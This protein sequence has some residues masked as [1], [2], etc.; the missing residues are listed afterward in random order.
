MPLHILLPSFNGTMKPR[1][2]RSS[3]STSNRAQTIPMVG[4]PA[5]SVGGIN[6]RVQKSGLVHEGE[7]SAHFAAD[8][9]GVLMRK[10]PDGIWVAVV[11]RLDMSRPCPTS[12]NRN[13]PL[14]DG[15]FKYSRVEETTLCL[16]FT[17]AQQVVDQS[18]QLWAIDSVTGNRA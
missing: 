18:R 6:L 7:I 11:S 8:D 16:L 14:R 12:V 9:D 17:V 4:R 1:T 2:P 15:E 3:A 5:G 10:S 13:W